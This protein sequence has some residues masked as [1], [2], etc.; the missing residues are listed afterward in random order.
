MFKAVKLLFLYTETPL[1]VGSGSS[2]G[3]VDLPIQRERH[4][5]LPMI[6]SSGIKGKLRSAFENNGLKGQPDLMKTIFGPESSNAS[7]HAGALSPG[8][9]RIL[10][11]PVRSLKGVFAWI[12][13][14]LIL[15]RFARDLQLAGQSC[16]WSIDFNQAID[17]T[18]L[19]PDNCQLSIDESIVLEEFTFAASRDAEVNKLATWLA[20]QAFPTGSEYQFWKNKLK[21]SLA[22]VSD[23]AFKD[24]CQFSTDIVARTKLDPV[25]KTVETGALWTEENLPGDTL[26]YT[27][28]FAC[29]PRVE[30]KPKKPNG[31]DD[32]DAEGILEIVQQHLTNGH[33]RLQLGGNETVGRGIVATRVFGR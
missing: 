3:V 2:L 28:L 5:S 23:D 4:T 7:D 32:L 8:D 19:V 30:T 27:P 1:H 9:G 31:T 12:T 15:S 14:P 13:C 24:F 33:A 6:Q 29:D 18:A 11:F 10:L 21:T 17:S 22:I 16:T 20:D 26:L 25:K